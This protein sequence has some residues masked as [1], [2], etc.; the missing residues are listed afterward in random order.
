ML[1][2]CK[3]LL[4][5]LFLNFF[6]VHDNFAINDQ[7]STFI[8]TGIF[9][10][11]NNEDTV[12]LQLADESGYFVPSAT[13]EFTACVVNHR[14]TFHIENITTPR[15]IKLVS[16]TNI[17][18][19]S[20][21]PYLVKGGDSVFIREENNIWTFAGKNSK[22]YYSQYEVFKFYRESQK[23]EAPSELSK[24]QR[25]FKR[26]DLDGL[27]CM[28]Y[29]NN[30]KKYLNAEDY[31]LIKAN[32]ISFYQDGEKIIPIL[33]RFGRKIDSLNY[34]LKGYVDPL[35]NKAIKA[36]LENQQIVKFS[37]SFVNYL[38]D[39]YEFDSCIL[40][41]T[42]FYLGKAF[43]YFA[44]NFNHELREELV[45]TLLA[46]KN[47]RRYNDSTAYYIDKAIKENIIGRK[48]YLT[49]LEN[50]KHLTTKGSL[51]YNF[52]L[53]NDKLKVIRL[54]N[55]KGRTVLLDFWYSQCGPCAQIHPYIEKLSKEFSQDS[56]IVVA[57]SVD[58]DRSIW[59]K[60]ISD[61]IRT[62]KH[63][64][65]LYTEGKGANH[66]VIKNFRVSGYPTIILIDKNGRMLPP[67]IDP[68]LDNGKNI[69]YTI[70]NAI[71]EE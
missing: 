56:F 46:K 61:G 31:Y 47:S 27:K 40:T 45:Y 34:Y 37:S 21:F 24:I 53:P 63:S 32:I 4:G 50:L 13:K 59:L 12:K 19:N 17:I 38:I 70:R 49:D 35:W 65:N 20:L 42:A 26:I 48:S 39:Q 71:L 29:L 23:I 11:L 68:R 66:P 69:E 43:N 10:S 8:L 52:S 30:L 5:T 57:I 2:R 60:S 58:K 55:F 44:Y 22:L 7:S 1:N 9:N 36:E 14:F 6:L 33:W 16:Q 18:A 3:A 67:V 41:N 15:Y 64:I 62:S 25:Y 51:A 54:S 28:N